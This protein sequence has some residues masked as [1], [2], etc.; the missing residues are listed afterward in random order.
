MLKYQTVI[1]ESGFKISRKQNA[2]TNLID[3]FLQIHWIL[4]PTHGSF[5]AF[6]IESVK[7]MDRTTC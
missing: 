6:V 7:Q 4:F 5:K 3:S 2:L 1:P